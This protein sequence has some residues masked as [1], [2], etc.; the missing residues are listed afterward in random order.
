MKFRLL[1][2]GFLPG[3]QNMAIDEAVLENIAK[4]QSEPTLRF[5]GWNPPTISIGY[6]QSLEEE[7]DL[8]A[9]KNLGVDTVRRV[10]GGGAVLHDHEITYSIHIP[11]ALGLVPAG[12]LESYEKICDGVIK[13]LAVLGEVAPTG[14]IIGLASPRRLGLEAKFV[15][16]NDLVV[17]QNGG[18]KKISGNAQ[19]RKQGILLQ[20]G[21]I[22]LKVDVDKMFSLL[23]VPSEKL[24]GKLIDDV[25]Q[26][27]TSVSLALGREVAFEEAA[28]A[29]EKGFAQAFPEVSFEDGTLSS[30][31]KNLAEKLVKEKYGAEGWN[32]AR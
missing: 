25:K 20:H 4:A 31:E 17:M 12:I 11:E 23:K 1:K 22:L 16:L 9:C 13:G 29:L 21:T 27:V 8:M 14:R 30:E 2:T 18:M 5:Y 6:F 26:R 24:K 3:A 32:N 19:T 28:E 15:P 7:V 10:T